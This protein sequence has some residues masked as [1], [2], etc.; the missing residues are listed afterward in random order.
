MLWTEEGKG[1]VVVR[2]STNGSWPEAAARRGII[3]PDQAVR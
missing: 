1:T 2:R 3:S